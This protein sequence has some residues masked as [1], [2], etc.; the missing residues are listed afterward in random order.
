MEQTYYRGLVGR[1]FLYLALVLLISLLFLCSLFLIADPLRFFHKPW[2]SHTTMLSPNMREQAIGLLNTN[3]YDSVIL[4]SSMLANTSMR[5]AS[6]KLGGEFINISVPATNL[7]ERKVFLDKVLQNKP[8][9]IIYS[10]DH[11]YM[12]FE[13]DLKDNKS[14]SWEKLYHN[15]PF[16]Y[17]LYYLTQDN[18]VN[19]WRPYRNLIDKNMDL[20]AS[21]IDQ[22]VYYTGFGGLE[23]WLQNIDHLVM[24]ETLLKDVLEESKKHPYGKTRSKIDPLKAAGAKEY[25]N[26]YLLATIRAHP[27]TEFHLILPPY[28][29]LTPATWLHFSEWQFPVHLEII[30]YLVQ[31]AQ[32]LPN[33]HIYGWDD[34]DFPDSIEIYTDR[35]HYHPSI[36]SRMLDDIRDGNELT[37]ARLDDY[38]QKYENKTRDFDLYGFIE[39]VEALLAEGKG[40]MRQISEPDR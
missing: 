24:H 15:N 21:W 9:N 18:I 39:R 4:G 2:F 25:I 33:L 27:E 35:Y 23:N 29:R 1:F 17:F 38:L 16:R 28:Y 12:N 6:Q 8:K 40:G 7:R 19:F 31:E 13:N 37:P 11:F 26:K 22:P 36:N 3:K 20:P 30:R 5:E 32:N 10:F 34:Q 14:E